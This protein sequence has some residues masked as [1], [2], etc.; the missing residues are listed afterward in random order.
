[1]GL[2]RRRWPGTVMVFVPERRAPQVLDG[3]LTVRPIV[4]GT[5]EASEPARTR[6]EPRDW[7]LRDDGPEGE[8]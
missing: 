8:R 7:G 2:A 1:M 6:L 4:E 3:G 5:H